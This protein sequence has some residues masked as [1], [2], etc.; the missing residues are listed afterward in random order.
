MVPVAPAKAGA[1]DL[2]V[3]K[4]NKPP[5]SRLSGDDGIHKRLAP[6]MAVRIVILP[7]P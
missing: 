2:V 1:R 7:N 4:F 3:N 6:T 5:D